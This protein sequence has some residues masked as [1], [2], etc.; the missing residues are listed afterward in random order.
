[1]NGRALVSS[2]LCFIGLNMSVLFKLVGVFFQQVGERIGVQIDV[3]IA[4]I[5]LKN[6]VGCVCGFY[7]AVL[8]KR[9]IDGIDFNLMT[10][11]YRREVFLPRGWAINN[12]W[13]VHD[14]RLLADKNLGV[15][16]SV[17]LL[18][19]EDLFALKGG[20]IRYCCK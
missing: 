2:Q 3:L 17:L 10:R 11:R 15:H 6:N 18:M 12:D 20:V 14:Q 7:A 19:W 1:M 13:G 5:E 16:P 4:P 9:A 8:G